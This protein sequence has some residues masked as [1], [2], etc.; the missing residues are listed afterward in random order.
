MDNMLKNFFFGFNN[1]FFGM[2]ILHKICC[3]IGVYRVLNDY[4]KL[5]EIFLTLYF[6][7]MILTGDEAIKGLPF[8]APEKNDNLRDKML[9]SYLDAPVADISPEQKIDTDLDGK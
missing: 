4:G 7:W 5:I 1:G 9:K 8:A 6:K 3:T 2:F